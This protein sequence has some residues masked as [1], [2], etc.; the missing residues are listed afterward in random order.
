MARRVR[1]RSTRQSVVA[2]KPAARPR[3]QRDDAPAPASRQRVAPRRIDPATLRRRAQRRR[4]IVAR[5]RLIAVAAVIAGVAV[6]IHVF[7]RMSVFEIR[8]IAV[9]GTSA[10]PDLLIR[11]RIDPVLRGETIFTV[12]TERVRT[13]VEQLPFVHSVRVD[14]HLPDGISIHIV[15]YQP[16]A[17]GVSDSGSWL[18]ARDGRV[19]TRSR[20]TDWLGRVPIVRL[21]HAHVAAGDRVGGEPAL[22]LLRVIPPSFP[23]SFR[24]VEIG[25]HGVIAQIPDGPEVRFGQ[26]DD[27]DE[28]LLVAERLLTMYGRERLGSITYIDVSVPARPAVLT[29]DER[30]PAPAQVTSASDPSM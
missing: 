3:R 4:I 25:S 15:E 2:E 19:L 7:P 8:G 22:R 21:E 14:R 16:L 11:R 13:E 30:A 9:E 29:G 17:L 12:D 18:V 10:V 27:F 20:L 5:L 6:V 1:H 24:S 23:G 26:P 28:K